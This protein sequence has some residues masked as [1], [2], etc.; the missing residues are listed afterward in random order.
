[1]CSKNLKIPPPK[2]NVTPPNYPYHIDS[3]GLDI[4]YFVMFSHIYCIISMQSCFSFSNQIAS[5]PK[6][7]RLSL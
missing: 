3:N 1:M 4:F 2:K 7:A 5:F 6:K